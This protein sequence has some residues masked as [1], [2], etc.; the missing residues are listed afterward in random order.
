MVN[1]PPYFCQILVLILGVTIVLVMDGSPVGRGCR[2]LMLSVLYKKRA[3]PLAWLVSQGSKGHFS[4]EN[5][6]NLI[7]QVK[8][9][10]PEEARKKLEHMGLEVPEQHE[11]DKKAE[12]S[13]NSE[14]GRLYRAKRNMLTQIDW[15]NPQFSYRFKLIHS[16]RTKIERLFSRM[17]ER[18]KMRRVY[19]RGVGNIWGHVL[20]FINLLH[21]LANVTGSYGV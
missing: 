18:F 16:L 17:K 13:P 7:E 9:I 21:I 15:D 12:C 2:T 14:I 5:H 3:L 8:E 20:K 6:I 11:C 4:E 10:I 19:K 1:D